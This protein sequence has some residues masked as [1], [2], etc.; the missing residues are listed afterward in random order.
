VPEWA[1][2]I[3]GLDYIIEMHDGLFNPRYQILRSEGKI[4]TSID[5]GRRSDLKTLSKI[6][7]ESLPRDFGNMAK[8]TRTVSRWLSEMSENAI[9]ARHN[10]LP[11]GVLL[12]SQE[13]YPVLDRKLAMLCYIA[14]AR[15]FR[16]RGV[17][18][19]LVNE[20]CD[21]LRRRGKSGIEVDVSVHNLP[22]RIFYTRTDFVP[23]RYSKRYMPHDDGIFYRKEF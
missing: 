4:S 5:R 15:N 12:L 6:L 2:K 13:I 11:V 9:V 23:Y 18:K 22:A 16:H 17:G 19:A 8:T 7:H 21:I 10:D 20:A 3:D 1:G 14:V